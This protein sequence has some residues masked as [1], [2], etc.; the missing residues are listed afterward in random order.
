MVGHSRIP[1]KVAAAAPVIR[2]IC[3]TTALAPEMIEAP[4]KRMERTV[5]EPLS[6]RPTGTRAPMAPAT[7]LP[8][9]SM[10]CSMV[11]GPIAHQSP[12][13]V[14][15]VQLLAPDQKPLAP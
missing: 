9:R 11:P 15:G 1:Q 8:T 7:W 6:A 4:R 5:K 2:M 3:G 10:I 12:G 14:S 13:I